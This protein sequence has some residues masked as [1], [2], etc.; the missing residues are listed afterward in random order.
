MPQIHNSGIAS[1]L[2]V[3]AAALLLVTPVACSSGAYGA[4]A[5]APRPAAEP[6]PRPDTQSA[7]QPDLAAL[8]AIANARADSL[9]HVYTAADVAFMTGMIGHHSQAITMARWVPSHGSSA[10][11]RTLAERIIS[12]QKDEIATMQQWLRERDQ[13]VPDPTPGSMHMAMGGGGNHT[14]MPGMLTDEQMKQLDRARGVDFDRL[15]LTDMIQH[16]S[17][18]LSMVKDLFDTI[19]GADDETIFKFASDVNVDQTTEIARMQK[20]LASL[21]PE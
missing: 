9:R 17:G 6:A 20:L 15:F 21:S 7:A 8:T 3:T 12:S 18:A 14:M 5:A 1:A 13:P 11:L 19:G 4:G 16:H 10:S 2:L